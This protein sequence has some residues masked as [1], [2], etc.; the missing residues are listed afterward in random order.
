MW[1]ITARYND[2]P[3]N[4]TLTTTSHGQ[5]LQMGPV[6][7]LYKDNLMFRAEYK[8]LFYEETSSIGNSRGSE[9]SIGIGITF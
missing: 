8:H 1:D 4:E 6:L 3:S 7:V 9:L 2:D 5:R